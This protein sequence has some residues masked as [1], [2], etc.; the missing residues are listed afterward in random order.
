MLIFVEYHSITKLYKSRYLSMVRM[1]GN[2]TKKEQP[3]HCGLF[4]YLTVCIW[5]DCLT[6][7]DLFGIAYYLCY[8]IAQD[9]KF[10][11]AVDR[12]ICTAG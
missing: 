2:K 7:H 9:V 3:A 4:F 1:H 6:R 11:L 8:H 5:I 10:A 12:V